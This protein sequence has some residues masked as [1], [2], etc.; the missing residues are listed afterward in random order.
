MALE[1]IEM[2]VADVLNRLAPR[3]CP[4]ADKHVSRGK[5][6]YVGDSRMY[7]WPIE[8]GDKSNPVC[9]I[10]PWAS[11]VT[12]AE[13]SPYYDGKNWSVAHK[14]QLLYDNITGNFHW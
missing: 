14:R 10:C 1:S 3:D 11:G 12:Y 5:P 13:R 8:C 9:R 2:R 4:G 7:V 6:R